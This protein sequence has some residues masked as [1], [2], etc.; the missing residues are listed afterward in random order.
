[1]N[2]QQLFAPVVLVGGWMMMIGAHD[3]FAQTPPKEN[4]GVETVQLTVIDLGPELPGMTGRGLRMRRITVAPGGVIGLHDHV[5]RP[6]IDYIMQGSLVDHRGAEAKEYG[7]G[8]TIFE[9]TKTVHWLENK[10]TTPAVFVTSDIL[11]QP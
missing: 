3:A 2:A 7:P 1:M 5:E 9:T 6:A 10:G 4:K 8:M 11:K